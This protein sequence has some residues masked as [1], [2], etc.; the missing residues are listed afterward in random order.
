MFGWKSLWL[1]GGVL[2]L[3]ACSQNYSEK[4][5]DEALA[6]R[7][8]HA[9]AGA[10]RTADRL[11]PSAS[12]ETADSGRQSLGGISVA[13]PQG[14]NSVSPSSSMRLAEYRLSGESVEA[15]DASLAVFYFGPN[16]GGAVESN[17][18]R[19]YGQFS[20]PDGGSTKDRARRWDKRIDDMPVALVDISGTYSGGMGPMGQSQGE[21]PEYRMLGAIVRSPAGHF[22]F[23]LVGPQQTLARWGES[24]E[25]FIASIQRE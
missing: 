7:D 3:L 8:L 22:F 25:Q 5:V 23:K 2:L 6:E 10:G 18:E 19:W 24:F 9:F 14:W 11:S 1:G 21:E 20:Q 16:Q 17:I 13:V 15:A 4:R 12:R